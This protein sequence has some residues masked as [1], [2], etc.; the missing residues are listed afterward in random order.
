M[1]KLARFKRESLRYNSSHAT[2][3]ER[4]GGGGMRGRYGT[5]LAFSCLEHEGVDNVGIII[6]TI[7]ITLHGLFG[8]AG[9]RRGQ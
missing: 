2:W 5:I 7:L 6:P 3:L 8:D 9:L 1:G 4:V